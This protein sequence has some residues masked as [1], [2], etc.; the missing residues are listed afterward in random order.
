MR[1]Q[2]AGGLSFERTFAITVTNVNS[3]PSD[4]AL[5]ATTVAENAASGATIGQFSSVDADASD[6]HTYS[7]VTGVGSTDNAA[8]TI[9]GNA[10]KLAT[11]PNF[12]TR[13]AT[14]SAFAVRMRAA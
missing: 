10:L 9:D 2:D 1:A 4:I 7:L 14:P 13:A 5:S 8:F 12:E 3:A 11:T 6:T